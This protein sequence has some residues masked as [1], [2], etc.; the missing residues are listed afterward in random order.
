M[1]KR[2]LDEDERKAVV[3]GLKR[4]QGELEK[5]KSNLQYN[6]AL[7]EKQNILRG[8]DDKWRNYLRTQKDEGDKLVLKRIKDSIKV[9]EESVKIDTEQ[10]DEGV[11]VRRIVGVG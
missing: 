1:V 4:E 6:E 2:Q 10:L 7:L 5:L 9:C 8:F 11:E 3:K